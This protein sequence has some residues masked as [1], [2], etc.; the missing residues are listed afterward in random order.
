[1]ERTQPP[2]PLQTSGAAHV[3]GSLT[4]GGTLLQVPA[5]APTPHE[6][7]VPPHAALQ[8]NPSTQNVLVHWFGIVQTVP[9]A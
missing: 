9:F 4:P 7:Q 1:M 6:E 8:Q 2:L 3:P 5:S